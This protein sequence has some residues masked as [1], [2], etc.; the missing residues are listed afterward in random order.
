MPTNVRPDAAHAQL[1]NRALVRENSSNVGPASR[2]KNLLKDSAKNPSRCRPQPFITRCSKQSTA[3]GHPNTPDFFSREEEKMT[4]PPPP[5][6]SAGW[7]PDPTG[8]PG[9]MYWDGEAW[10]TT[11]PVPP[12]QRTRIR[13]QPTKANLIKGIVGVGLLV[14]LV[15]YNVPGL[16]A[17]CTSISTPRG[18]PH[19]PA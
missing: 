6:P 3:L 15:A 8:K 9:Q 1:Q 13:I 14:W 18:A 19:R 17:G 4:T 7:Y 11:G 16:W 10:H 5:Q 2:R 12:K